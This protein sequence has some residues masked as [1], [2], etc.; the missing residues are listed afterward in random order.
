MFNSLALKNPWVAITALIIA[1]GVAVYSYTK[2]LK[3]ASFLQK[4]WDSVTREHSS[5]LEQEKSKLDILYQQL[6]KTNP[7]SALRRK[8]IDKI[9]ELYPDFL[10][11]IDAEKA[12]INELTKSY[13]EYLKRLSNTISIKG[14]EQKMEETAYQLKEVRDKID[15]KDGSLS[16]LMRQEQELTISYNSLLKQLADLKNID[17]FGEQTANVLK[18]INEIEKALNNLDAGKLITKQ[19]YNEAG[20]FQRSVKGFYFGDEFIEFFDEAALDS[21]RKRPC[22]NWRAILS[23]VVWR[24]ISVGDDSFLVF[25]F[26]RNAGL[27]FGIFG[28]IGRGFAIARAALVNRRSR[29]MDLF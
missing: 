10:K 13:D 23:R 7:Q 5:A 9:N 14:V 12:S 24:S 22:I 20:E 27:N 8:I 15:A 21:L 18:Q 25:A 19:F 4:M 11:N 2:S 17:V 26:C 16:K 29:R 28:V 3:E 6:L 1:A